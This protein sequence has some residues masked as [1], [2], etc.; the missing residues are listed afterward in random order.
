[1]SGSPGGPG[2]YLYFHFCTI[3]YARSPTTRPTR[4]VLVTDPETINPSIALKKKG[5]MTGR[6]YTR[7]N[8]IIFL[9]AVF[10][11]LY[12]HSVTIGLNLKQLHKFAICNF[13]I[14]ETDIRKKKLT[15]FST[16]LLSCALSL[17]V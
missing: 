15:L 14:S 3:Q 5:N 8:C 10:K 16:F 4:H 13:K 12:I 6:I 2:G 17:F 9:P 7:I 1:M 11:N